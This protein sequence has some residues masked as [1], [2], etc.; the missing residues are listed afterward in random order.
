MADA[1]AIC[2]VTFEP[3]VSVA[4]ALTL[5]EPLVATV[6]TPVAVA[7]MAP[8]FDVIFTF[9]PCSTT[10][11]LADLIAMSFD[12][13]ML[14]DLAATSSTTLFFLVESTIV[15]FS[16]PSVSSKMIRCPDFDLMT[17][18]SFLPLALVSGGGSFLFHS[19]P[20]TIGRS[21]SPCSNTIRT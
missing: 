8:D 10:L 18:I 14:T 20:M 4:S 6:M 1:P 17:L 15:T 21:T 3:I 5:I 12:D 19:E 2:I 7:L 13:S 9:W 16:A 11:P